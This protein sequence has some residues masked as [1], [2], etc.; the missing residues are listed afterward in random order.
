MSEVWP[1]TTPESQKISFLERRH[2]VQIY[3]DFMI[4]K[5]FRL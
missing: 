1:V 5:K 3:A 4:I 2:Q